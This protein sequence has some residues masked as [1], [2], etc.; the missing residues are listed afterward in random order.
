[1]PLA[2]N[3]RELQHREKT[4][5]LGRFFWKVADA[6]HWKQQEGNT[7]QGLYAFS[8]AGDFYGSLND[9]DVGELLALLEK[10]RKAFAKAPPRKL[11]LARPSGPSADVL[12]PERAAVVRVHARILPLP[13]GCAPINK[14][15][16][17]DHLWVLEE[18]VAAIAKGLSTGEACDL[19]KTLVARIAR[20]HLLDDVRGEPDRWRAGEVRRAE[21]RATRVTSKEGLAARVSGAF[22]MLAAAGKKSEDGRALG[23]RGY[24]GTIEGELAVSPSPA[25]LATFRL[26]ARGKAWGESTYTPSPPAGKFPLSVAFVLLSSGKKGEKAPPFVVSPQG[27]DDGRETYLAPPAKEDDK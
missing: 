26:L 1:M 22:S 15:V 19:P 11:E 23:E 13:A 17:R 10:A 7:T 18:E 24:E 14:G 20:W 6:G 12:P 4:D 27:L 16:G 21:L 2:A 9:R 8:A 5:E 25:R 3:T